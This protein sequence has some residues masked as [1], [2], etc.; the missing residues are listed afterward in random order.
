MLLDA[1]M[2]SEP[3]ENQVAL[4]VWSCCKTNAKIIDWK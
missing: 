3:V 2:H 4:K 1:Q